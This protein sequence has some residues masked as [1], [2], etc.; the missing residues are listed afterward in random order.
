MRYEAQCVVC[1]DVL[2]E[3]KLTRLMHCD[4]VMTRL[5]QPSAPDDYSSNLN[6]VWSQGVFETNFQAGVCMEFK[7]PGAFRRWEKEAKNRGLVP[8]E[9]RDFKSPLL[10][11]LERRHIADKW[12]HERD[13]NVSGGLKELK[14]MEA[15]VYG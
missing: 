7:G 12:K 14:Q 8:A 11:S 4:K 6:S 9:L 3:S 2:D 10:S 1:G 15:K 13:V 5:T